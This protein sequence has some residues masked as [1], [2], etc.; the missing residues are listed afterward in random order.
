MGNQ[1]C[2]GNSLSKA[3]TDPNLGISQAQVNTVLLG[4]MTGRTYWETWM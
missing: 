3:K 4:N 2:M 1:S